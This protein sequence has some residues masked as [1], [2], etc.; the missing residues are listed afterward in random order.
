MTAEDRTLEKYALLC[1]RE[2]DGAAL[3]AMERAR[4]WYRTK[5]TWSGKMLEVEAYPMLPH[6]QRAAI[7]KMQ[8]TPEAMKK[9]NQRNAEK[10]FR[11]LAEINFRD[12]EDYF[13]TGTIEAGEGE[14]LPTLE[15][16]EK[17]FSNFIKRLN[18]LRKARGL[19][20]AKYLAVIE[21]WEEGSRQVRLH[22]HAL[23]EGGLDRDTMENLWRQKRAECRRLVHAHLDELCG[24]LQKGPRGRKRWRRSKGNLK[25]PRET[26][27]D[28]KMNARAAWRIAEDVAGRNAALERLYPG[29]RVET[30]NGHDAVEVRS[31]PYMPG[32]YIYARLRKIET[33]QERKERNRRWTKPK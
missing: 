10:T 27:A 8:G 5:A 18:R 20:N 26:H 16:V 28:R 1:D 22:V 9:L 29:Y 13:F 12:E 14:S 21:G 6:G 2:M 17:L 23:I 33:A 19:K 3:T 4:G 7:H 25:G 30:I 15:Q 32:C 11:R 24:Y 31:N